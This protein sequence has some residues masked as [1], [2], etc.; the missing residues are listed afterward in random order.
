MPKLMHLDCSR[1]QAPPEHLQLNHTGADREVF[2]YFF[3]NSVHERIFQKALDHL[4]VRI[5]N[6]PYLR[7]G[8]AAV[9]LNCVA[10]M[11][12]DFLKYPNLSQD[13]SYE[14]DY[15][16]VTKKRADSEICVGKHRNV[17]MAERL[18]DEIEQWDRIVV[19]REHLDTDV[20][21]GLRR[22]PRIEA[23]THR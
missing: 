13:L 3:S 23:G 11:Y 15:I 14:L 20:E 1:A 10:G 7:G 8:C 4:E 22:R 18:A 6:G 21:S 2:D 9:V 12:T 19:Q 16:L 17:A 5:L